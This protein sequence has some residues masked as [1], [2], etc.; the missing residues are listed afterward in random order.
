MMNVVITG[1]TKG[2]GLSMAIEFL[3]AGCNVAVS[4]KDEKNLE[5]AQ[6]ALEIYKGR[7]LFIKCDVAI[8]EDVENLWKESAEKWGKIDYWINN[9]G[10]NCP[11]KFIYETDKI[12]VDAVINTNLKGM[13]YGSQVASGNMLKQG[14]GQIWNMEGLGSNNMIQRKTILYGTTKH[15]LTYF[16][17]G[18]AKELEGTPVLAG[19]LSPGMMLTDFITKQPDGQE[20]SMFENKSSKKIFNTLAD[21]PETVAAYFVPRMLANRKNGAHI[22]WLTRRKS[23]LRFAVSM[24]RKR[25]IV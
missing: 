10:I 25:E 14:G 24:F 7:V 17:K 23:Y 6:E 2:A 20:P 8:K 3:K 12:Y 15:A 1:S 4:G 11:H 21:R 19:R 18:L 5:K 16:T 22:V 9:A 13:I